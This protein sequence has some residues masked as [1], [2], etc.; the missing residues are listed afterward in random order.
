MQST[1]DHNLPSFFLDV[2]VD[3]LTPWARGDG[4]CPTCEKR[5]EGM[6]EERDIWHVRGSGAQKGEAQN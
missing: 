2:E 6:R 1:L 4:G 5:R 3:R